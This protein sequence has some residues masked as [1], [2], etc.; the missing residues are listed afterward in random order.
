MTSSLYSP[1]RQ[2]TASRLPSDANC[3]VDRQIPK[4]L[5]SRLR[6]PPAPVHYASIRSLATLYAIRCRP[7]ISQDFP[8]L[9]LA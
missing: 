4:G 3:D 9:S 8:L 6:T 1:L 5:S 2:L 7:Q